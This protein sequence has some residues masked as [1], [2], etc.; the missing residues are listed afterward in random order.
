MTPANRVAVA[1]SI[2]PRMSRRSAGS[3]VSAIYQKLCVNSWLASGLR[4]I[5]VNPHDEVAELSQRFPEIEFV[6]VERDARSTG[7]RKTPFIADML[8]TLLAT[9]QTCLGIINADLVLEPAGA[10]QRIAEHTGPAVL[11]V[12][13]YD[14]ASLRDGALR[15][16]QGGF[17]CFFFDQEC[18]KELLR[19]AGLFAMGVPWWDCWLPGMA[20]LRNREVRIL[21][22]PIAAHLVHPQGYEAAIHR[23]YA[24]AFADCIVQ[25]A[26]D[27]SA[28]E[29]RGLT[30][31]VERCRELRVLPRSTDVADNIFDGL[32]R[33]MDDWHRTLL[34]NVINLGADESPPPANADSPAVE[35][36]PHDVFRRV[37]ER[38]GIGS[39]LEAA[40]NLQST[41]KFAEARALIETWLVRVPGDDD[42][43]GTLGDILYRTGDYQ[44]AA[45]AF[46]KAR[47]QQPDSERFSNGLGMSLLASGR[48]KEATKCFQDALAA[49]PDSHDTHYNLA[50]ALFASGIS[51]SALAV[52]DTALAKWPHSLPL[53]QL[54]QQWPKMFANVNPSNRR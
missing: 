49:A 23:R 44:G 28:L 37:S 40:I 11:A 52:T 6:S 34:A 21:E 16:Y 5:S 38:L 4:V 20:G 10:W 53:R 1:T 18:A 3:D 13:R 32:A 54:R 43:L 35:T 2:P 12:H 26:D 8:A 14:M 24:F 51:A 31:V 22:R 46:E 15:K 48:L 19:N 45:A 36:S 39:A 47:A 17:D 27:H 29:G 30:N 9:S 42:L 33:A 7:G 25:N 41:G 50:V